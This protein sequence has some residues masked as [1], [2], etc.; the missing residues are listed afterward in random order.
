MIKEFP[1]DNWPGWILVN[2][3]AISKL[4]INNTKTDSYKEVLLRLLLIEIYSWD[5]HF[6]FIPLLH[7]FPTRCG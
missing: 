5:A 7:S 1:G 6:L 2:F 3:N 4:W